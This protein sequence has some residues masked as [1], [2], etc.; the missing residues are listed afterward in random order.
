MKRDLVQEKQAEGGDF[1]GELGENLQ[2]D[3]TFDEDAK[4]TPLCDSC[5]CG[6]G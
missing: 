5:A 6:R 1:E 2:R 3:S 4:R